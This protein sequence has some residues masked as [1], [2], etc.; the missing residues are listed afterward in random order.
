MRTSG[1]TTGRAQVSPGKVDAEFK[2]ESTGY[3]EAQREPDKEGED[4]LVDLS[5]GGQLL[6]LTDKLQVTY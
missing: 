1:Y 3:F 5:A 6:R 2:V 4:G